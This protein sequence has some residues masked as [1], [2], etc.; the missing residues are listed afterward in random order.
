MQNIAIPRLLCPF[1]SRINSHVYAVKEHTDQWVLEFGLCSEE[2]LEKYHAENYSAFTSRFY[3]DADYE[4]L[5]IANDLI[6]LLFIID[7]RTDAQFSKTTIESEDAL[8]QFIGKIIAIA[9]QNMTLQEAKQE[10]NPVF[11]AFADVWQ[12]LFCATRDLWINSFAKEIEAIF[13]AAVWEYRNSFKQLPKV[14][15]Y[16]QKRMYIGAANI[17]VALIEPMEKIYLAESVK[18]HEF[19]QELGK[20]ACNVICIS[21]DLFSLNKEQI[22]GDQHNLPSILKNEKGITLEEAMSLTAEIHD[23]EVNKFIALAKQ[24]PSFD[25]DTNGILKRYVNVLE[26]QMAGNVVWSE[27]ETSRYPFTYTETTP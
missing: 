18:Q 15:E 12:R 4:H 13:M 11:H 7:D 21:N 20:L 10:R 9:N 25:E 6:A 27:S 8:N 2:E 26:L 17:A 19:V 3:P 16:L 5:C 22:S 23:E 1:T 24:L 14:E